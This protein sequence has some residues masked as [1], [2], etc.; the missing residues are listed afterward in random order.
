MLQT[1][2]RTA[3]PVVTQQRGAGQ[4]GWSET[5]MAAACK[6]HASC[7]LQVTPRQL[8]GQCSPRCQPM[9][10][11]NCHPQT[12]H[13][14]SGRVS[15]SPTCVSPLPTAT[16]QWLAAHADMAAACTRAAN[17]K[18]HTTCRVLV[19]QA[20]TSLSYPPA[21]GSAKLWLH[22]HTAAPACA[23]GVRK[24][25]IQARCQCADYLRTTLRRSALSAPSRRPVLHATISMW[26]ARQLALRHRSPDTNRP[27]STGYQ[28]T[29]DTLYL[30]AWGD[31]LLMDSTAACSEC[32]AL[33]RAAATWALSRR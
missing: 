24:R 5:F 27:E 14:S 12:S 7:K 29:A 1:Q 15:K 28:A 10:K 2:Y 22:H 13:T 33:P 3:G 20:F 6:E 11:C 30:C 4:A 9:H 32:S 19:S 31:C 17:S 18:W 25:P 26:Q 16:R 21:A 23:A 8:V